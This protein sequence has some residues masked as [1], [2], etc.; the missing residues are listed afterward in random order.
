[1]AAL[2][3]LCS[4]IAL[5]D[6]G[7][8]SETPD[9]DA[10]P[11][12]SPFASP[13]R[14]LEGQ[15]TATSD[16]FALPDGAREAR[17]YDAPVNYKEAKGEWQP[18]EE[19][20]EEQA[21]GAIVNGNNG[22]D[23]QLPESLDNA[24]IRLSASG[25]WVAQKP[26]GFA[27]ENAE[28]QGETAVYDSAAEGV[29]FQ[30]SGLADGLKEDIV[31]ED[32]SA[33]STL[34][35]L[36]E[37]ST[38]LTPSLNERGGVDFRDS[39]GARV[40]TI[41]APV[42]L[43][44]AETLAPSSA[45]R[46]GL[47][48]TAGG[49]WQLSVEAD[50]Q[51]LSAAG[52][53]W[54]VVIDPTV[55]VPSPTRSCMIANT[56]EFTMCGSGGWKPLYAQAKYAEAG[57]DQFARSLLQF[58]L[59]SIPKTASVISTTLGLYSPVEAKNV[60]RVDLYD[61]GRAWET[62]TWR[63]WWPLHDSLHEW[64]APGG[65]YGQFLM[66]Q[67][68]SLT[69][70]ERGGSQPGWWK[71][72]GANL[73]GLVQRWLTGEIKNNGLLLKLHE[74]SPH[75]CCIER[76]VQWESSAGAN[77]PYLQV[78]Y[79]P[80]ASPDSVVTSPSNGT[81][82][83]KRFRLTAAWQHSGVEGVTFQYKTDNNFEGWKNIPEGQ[84]ID[85]HSQ[86]VHWPF[87]VKLED[88]ASQPLFWNASGLTGKAAHQKVQIRAVLAGV[89]GADGYTK[90]VEGEVDKDT[91]GFNGTSAAIG[92]GVVDLLTGNFTV[93][94]N[95]VSIPGFESSLQ[96]SRSLSSRDPLL[97]PNGPLGPGWKTSI[98]VEGGGGSSWRK[99]NVET[100]SET[101]LTEKEVEKQV[102]V[103]EGVTETEII[104]EFVPET[105]TR[106]WAELTDT[107]GHEFNFPVNG[108]G[109]FVTP[110]GLSGDI[111]YRLNPNA[112]ALTEPSGNRTIFSNVGSGT[113]YLPTSVGEPGTGENKTR[114]VYE[115]LSGVR[116]LKWVIAPTPSGLTCPDESAWSTPGCHALRFNYSFVGE[117]EKLTSI[118]YF[119]PGSGGPWKVA[120]YG[121]NAAGQ[122]A[123]EW[124]PRIS[125]SLKETYTYE[126]GGELHTLTPRGEEP[127]TMQY[128]TV[129]GETADG[130][131]I[132]LKRA[133]L[134]GGT[135]QTTL[136]YGVPVSGSGAPYSMGPEAIAAW[137]QEDMPTDAT[138]IFPPSEVPSSPPSSYARARVYYLD[139]EGQMTNVA[140]PAGAGTTAPSIT[141][142]ETDATGD[143]TRELS[144]QNRLRALAE[145]AA[146]VAKSKELDT[147][148]R[149]TPD[150]SELQLEKGPIHQVRLESGTLVQARSY[151]TI[152][153]DRD[154][155]EP[156]AGEPLPHLPTT[157]TSGALVGES[158]LDKRTTE[159]RYNWALREQT[160]SIVDPEGLNIR[161]VF[162][163]EP[164]SGLPV[165]VR[166]PSNAGGGGAGST[167][168]IYYRPSSSGA[169]NPSTCES[170]VWAN[171]PC[172]IAP[173]AQPGTAG[174]PELLVRKFLAYNQ[175]GEPTE[176]SESPGGGSENVRKTTL[177]Y[178]SA[179][180]Q[181]T[182]K[183][184]GGGQPIPKVETLYSSTNGMPTTERFVCNSLQE[185]CTA[186][187]S[188]AATTTYDALGRATSYEDADGNKATTT[189]NA[190][191]QPVTISDGKGTQTLRY[192]STTGLP[193]EL[194]DSVAG[195]FT[196]SYDADGNMLKRGLPDGL[197]TETTYD[198]TDAAVH[199]TYTK[200]SSCGAS[201]TWL[202]F[203]VER[204]IDGQILRETSSL[205]NHAYV[206]DKAGRLTEA[207]ETPQG[208]SCTTRAYVYD[209]D[210]NR[211]KMW[212]RSPGIGGACVT[213]GG[214][215]QE[216]RYDA[217]DRLLAEG[218]KYDGFGRITNLPA[219]DA[220]GKELTTSYFA[221]DM[222]ASQSQGGI[223]NN[224]TLDAELRQ[225]SR[226]QAGGLEGT[227]IFHYDSVGDA[228]A[229]TERGSAWT[230]DIKG[231]EGEIVAVQ[232]SGLEPMLQLTNLH[233]DIVATAALNPAVTGLK[234]TATYDEFGNRT[235]GAVM[236]F[237]WLGGALR[238]T[239]LA[240]GVVQMGARS[241]V[242]QLGRFLSADPVRGGSANAYDY[243]N[244]DPV[245]QS[246][247][248][249]TK[250]YDNACDKGV[251]GCQCT[252]HIKMWSPVPWRMGVRFIRQCNRAG[253]ID[254]HAWHLWYWV[255]EQTG[256]GFVELSPPHYVNHYP[257][258]PNCRDTDPCQNHWD[259]SGTFEC[260]PGWEYQIGV[261]WQYKYNAGNEVGDVQTLTVKAQEY[262]L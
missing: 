238:R 119:A 45:V 80:R 78:Q 133:N 68:Q 74:E 214:S 202:D 84:V 58:N 175:L 155:P 220:G 138:A 94:R 224:F 227:E 96:F 134:L 98:P 24:P 127:W 75:V 236:R 22:F 143:V 52:R 234:A 161:S 47:E 158:L 108:D 147:E 211:E 25:A 86:T 150:G 135:A 105:I 55:T 207:Q 17:L 183:I 120:Q 197:T 189:Y 102:E 225:R 30:F 33:P 248:A 48:A 112:I 156:G 258:D 198:A 157:E 4:G 180:R 111:L 100:V 226:L 194:E 243:G 259:H 174:Q 212:T 260:H 91:G 242:P 66:Q 178:D 60:S 245:N 163:Y 182:K 167:Q 8:P 125:P 34:H 204:S 166:Q 42:M 176:I 171:L 49:K 83:A 262:C 257:G 99:L 126:S 210:S 144:A 104:T 93:S 192:D 106:S 218:L 205:V 252:L 255:D 10:G 117:K 191:G 159:S 228:P 89:P 162:V 216:Y 44:G 3:I 129:E 41:P 206:Y 2:L 79:I 54:P 149:Y 193:V 116:R 169:S 118:S 222:V 23:L 92:P 35:F 187:D 246:D 168:T 184:E 152:Q 200:T 229:W 77:K 87:A 85:Q 209:K 188:Q 231:I 140:S 239:E 82:T 59:D 244:A 122:L 146:S 1:L 201:C 154:A 170:T 177:T 21:S 213:S 240:S 249:G 124:D 130:R 69:T 70:A 223:T 145:G 76:A 203:G 185:S 190:F 11:G 12:A 241:Y 123:E 39:H 131:L 46:Y 36:L 5:A 114:M 232:E 88:R 139:A 109:K 128:G 195:L 136:A 6:A 29:S 51:W 90:L 230:R 37:A 110:S 57:S 250:P 208:G 67:P 28:L 53:S 113:E 56:A 13:G 61:L 251:I 19:G 186:F 132:A 14:E 181:L 15:R 31:L 97:E 137:G 50:R 164:T 26:L 165:E 72:S 247:L 16:T 7:S 256:N 38:G 233:G 253:G 199:L 65:D 63:Y 235:V 107:G 142:T 20:L 103:E 115:F 173:A 151:R 254:L 160:E 153:Y 71:F 81:K 172:K 121:Y 101:V 217:A 261:E 179:G 27:T 221:N 219:A 62:P 73:T 141:T 237:G 64:T 9:A 32:E 196:A 95:D 148:Y 40:A 18:I 43:D 215:S